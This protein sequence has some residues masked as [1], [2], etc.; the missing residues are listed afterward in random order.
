[1]FSTTNVQECSDHVS[2]Y[3][4]GCLT[5]LVDLHTGTG[6]VC[7]DVSWPGDR[8]VGWSIDVSDGVSTGWSFLTLQLSSSER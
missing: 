7:E 5:F 1:M 2:S 4:S 8:A 6:V 3:L